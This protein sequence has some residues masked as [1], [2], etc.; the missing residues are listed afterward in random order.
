M[1]E[2]CSETSSPTLIEEA[3]VAA[4]LREC[5]LF[6]ERHAELLEH[7]S[8]PHHRGSAVSLVERQVELLRE[9]NRQLQARFD[10]LVN[11]ARENEA[12]VVHVNRVAARLIE[13]ATL[14]EALRGIEDA[15]RAEFDVAHVLVLLRASAADPDG[16]SDLAGL[17]VIGADSEQERALTDFFRMGKT[18]CGPLA[19]TLAAALWPDAAEPPR[20]AALVPLDRVTQLG[21]LVLASQDPERFTRAMGSWFLEQVAALVAGACR[22]RLHLHRHDETQ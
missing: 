5:P 10:T 1:E 17:R 19:P 7:L 14:H 3:D 9:R 13:A 20:S 21:A 8:L 4:Y 12:R 11:A 18:E 16:R 6:F 22:A 2:L 15:I